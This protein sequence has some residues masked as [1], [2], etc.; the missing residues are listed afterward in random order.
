MKISTLSLSASATLLL[1]AAVLATLVVWSNEKRHDIEVKSNNLQQLQ[2]TFLVEI[3]RELDAYLNTGDANQLEIA[4][5]LLEQ[6]ESSLAINNDS[7][8][9]SL[10]R[11]LSHFIQSLDTDYRAAGKLAGNPRQLLAHAEAEM[12]DNNRRLADYADV[13]R[14]NSLS[15]SEQYLRL[16]RQLPPLVY[17]LSQLTQGYLIGKDQRLQSILQ[18]TIDELEIWHNRLDSLPL[19]GIYESQEID[20]FALGGA[21]EEVLEIGETYRSELLSLSNRYKREV[22]NTYNLLQDNQL[23]QQ[24][25]KQSISEVEQAMLE[26]SA[27]QARQ[28]QQLKKELQLALYTVVSVLALFAVIYLLL[29]QRRVVSPLKQLNHAFQKL[30]ESNS[31]ERLEINRRCET[32]QI[33]GHFNLLLQRFEEEDESQREQMSL[34]SQSLSNLV[35]RISQITHSTDETQ[36]VVSQAQSQT[37]EIRSLAHEVST[38]SSLVEQSAEQTML[39]MQISQSE[40]ELMLQA[41]EETQ[42]AVIQSHLS[43]SSLTTSV[44][45]VSKIIDVIGNIAE[46]TNLLALNAAIEA[47]RAGEQGRGFAVVA[48]EVRSLSQRTQA[49]LKEIMDILNQ[50]NQANGELAINMTG[51]EQATQRQ[52]ARA[53]GLSDVALSVQAQAS[54][55]AVTAKQGSIN[56]QQQVNY[57]DEFVHA[58]LMLKNQ[59]QSASQQSEVIG[60]EV[61]QS[62]QDIEANLGIANKETHL[63]HAA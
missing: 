32:G 51:I 63:S 23:I 27:T 26:L 46:Q 47:A 38:T 60:N 53:Q 9:E 58:M 6:I 14:S 35:E 34:V 17:Q 50:L 22:T 48:D 49:S 11:L 1:L 61:Q 45:D 39:Q 33:A 57:L 44:E 62:V 37:D 19:I 8:V 15:L 12:L 55:M 2:Q 20:E 10:R 41:T 7:D 29:Q 52:K 36:H 30:S 3:R 25:L 54:D 31:R 18:S 24:Q 13:G 59:A 28:N 21:E 5:T 16:T 42:Q 43:L 56:A 4:K 40:A